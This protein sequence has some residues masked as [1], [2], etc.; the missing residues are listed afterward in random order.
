MHTAS[1]VPRLSAL[2]VTRYRA[3]IG[4]DYW[5]TEVSRDSK[6]RRRVRRRRKTE[7]RELEGDRA[8]SQRLIRIARNPS[9]YGPHGSR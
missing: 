3:R 7:I 4:E 5:V 1:P 6:G 9:R 2:A 8:Q